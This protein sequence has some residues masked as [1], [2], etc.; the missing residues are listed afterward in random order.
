MNKKIILASTS[1]Q[2]KNL[3]AKTGLVFETTASNYE[4][5]MTLPLEPKEL[6]MHLSKGK[7]QAVAE[8]YRG[9]LI[10]AADTFIVH[11]D[12]ILGKPHTPQ[13]AKEMLKTLSG[14]THSIITGFTVLDTE[15]DKSISRAVEAKVYFK[16]LSEE[17][18]DNYIATGEP[19]D[20]A[21]A[22]AI[23]GLG[24]EFVEKIEG[25]YSNVVGLPVK[26]VIKILR[27][28]GVVLQ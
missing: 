16:K 10:I 3:L 22:Y 9:A 13:R 26:E 8:A 11:E 4:E 23:Q 24:S 25:D 27:D 15:S 5:D 19:L 18:M 20:K 12:K 7:A 6:A 28:F 2:R 14:D 17:E 21:G 1:L